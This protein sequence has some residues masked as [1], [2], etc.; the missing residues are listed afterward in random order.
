MPVTAYLEA[1]HELARR[2]DGRE[3]VV[4]VGLGKQDG[5]VVLVV[6]LERRAAAEN[7]DEGDTARPAGLPERFHGLR[8]V[9][10]QLGEGHLFSSEV[11]MMSEAI[12]NLSDI[13]A[14]NALQSVAAKWFKGDGLEAFVVVQKASER[15]SGR[16]AM[17]E[18]PEL[19][20]LMTGLLARRLLTELEGG[21]DPR[22]AGWTR[23]AVAEVTLAKGRMFDPL[24][25]A[26]G[27]GVLIGA[28]L[29]ARV[30]K[31]GAV[32][33]YEGVP[34]ELALLLRAG[35]DVLRPDPAGALSIP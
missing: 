13:G 32:E 12:A 34:E 14:V 31:I 1:S 30:R 6:A 15:V 7:D 28:I 11:D 26:I 17:A 18:L 3:G 22:V 4:S 35:E 10:R 16:P 27:G 5:E 21:T 23:E 25:L 2:L 29:A 20:R 24:T 8:V 33:F 9:V 19:T